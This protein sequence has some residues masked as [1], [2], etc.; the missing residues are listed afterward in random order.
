[1]DLDP[2]DPKKI[3]TRPSSKSVPSKSAALPISIILSSANLEEQIKKPVR[4]TP[5]KSLSPRSG[6]LHVL[7][8]QSPPREHSKTLENNRKSSPRKGRDK[9][10]SPR[11]DDT[12]FLQKEDQRMQ[13]SPPRRLPS[14]IDSNKKEIIAPNRIED[15]LEERSSRDKLPL[16][17]EEDQRSKST[18][19]TRKAPSKMNLN[20]KD[21]SASDPTHKESPMKAMRSALTASFQSKPKPSDNHFEFHNLIRAIK[22]DDWRLISAFLNDPTNNPNMQNEVT[23]NTLL[24]QIVVTLPKRLTGLN[25]FLENC[26]V[27]SLIRNSDRRFPFHFLDE[28][29]TQHPILYKALCE[30]ACL[31]HLINAIIMMAENIETLEPNYI[32]ALLQ[33]IPEGIIPEYTCPAFIL[34]MIKSRLD[35][36]KNIIDILK[37]THDTDPFYINEIGNSKL[38][39]AVY[40]RNNDF[41]KQHLKGKE[42]D[43]LFHKIVSDH[44]YP[45]VLLFLTNPFIT[46]LIKDK[47]GLAPYQYIPKNIFHLWDSLHSRATLEY[48]IRTIII[49][50]YEFLI[51]PNTNDKFIHNKID[52]LLQRIP[53]NILPKYATSDFIFSLLKTYLIKENNELAEIYK[54]YKADPNYQDKWGHTLLHHAVYLRDETWLE[55]LVKD[56]LIDSCKEN[57]DKLLPQG[58]LPS[59]NKATENM[60]RMLFIRD[61]MQRWVVSCALKN[62]LILET[63]LC[64]PTSPSADLKEIDF[65]D[66]KPTIENIKTISTE[67][68]AKQWVKD[69][70]DQDGQLPQSAA[71]IPAYATDDFLHQLI[72]H[73]TK[74]NQA[75][76]IKTAAEIKKAEEDEQQNKQQIE[77]IIETIPASKI[78]SNL[79][80]LNSEDS[81]SLVGLDSI[82]SSPR[83]YYK[84]RK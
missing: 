64:N 83:S 62:Q 74:R 42:I 28:D 84:D 72:I 7:R 29:S 19:P 32:K 61:S 45:A 11:V 39:F 33:T 46:T 23:K 78:R 66:I 59:N 73:H 18:S 38:S 22:E 40:L 31:D 4:T 58:L 12:S 20:K 57:N 60:R 30:R 17:K 47:K 77:N 24:H 53:S 26:R 82:S 27:N 51:D 35:S 14:A 10:E 41:L 8:H 69:G 67:I 48:I 50:N 34:S 49:R 71:K 2:T 6:A 81:I 70:T 25:L 75:F 16:Q 55:S 76:P 52:A 63:V 13:V 9:K 80:P 56:P 68:E 15:T 37:S 44:N 5:S 43:T 54:K 65:E 79:V 21:F 3:V 1:M 36:D